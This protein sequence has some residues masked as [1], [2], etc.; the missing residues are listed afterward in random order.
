MSL[1]ESVLCFCHEFFWVT[2]QYHIKDF[3][4][5]L[6]AVVNNTDSSVIFGVSSVAFLKYW[7][8][9]CHF[10]IHLEYNFL[11]TYCV[12]ASGFRHTGPNVCKLVVR[13]FR[14]EC[15]QHV[16]FTGSHPSKY[17]PCSKLLNIGDWTKTGVVNLA[18]PLSVCGNLMSGLM[19]C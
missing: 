9:Q 3:R 1:S 17:W 8:L 18:W 5:Y 13:S 2:L 14:G 7:G 16:M 4:V 12:G 15:Q 19:E 10:S 11:C 6:I